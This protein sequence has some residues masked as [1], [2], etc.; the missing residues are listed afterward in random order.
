M[1]QSWWSEMVTRTRRIATNGAG[2]EDGG[3]GGGVVG[4][5]ECT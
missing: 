3:C 1:W 2:S 4:R 5:L